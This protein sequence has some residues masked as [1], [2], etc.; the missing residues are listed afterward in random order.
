MGCEIS[1]FYTPHNVTFSWHLSLINHRFSAYLLHII[2][3]QVHPPKTIPEIRAIVLRK[4]H[5]F[6]YVK[7]DRLGNLH[8]FFLPIRE[9]EQTQDS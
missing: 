5:S 9:L 3:G 1:S 7:E 8:S 6:I 2:L 4:Y